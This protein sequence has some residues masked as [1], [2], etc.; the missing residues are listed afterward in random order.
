M[1]NQTPKPADPIIAMAREMTALVAKTNEY[2]RESRNTCCPIE[3]ERANNRHREAFSRLRAL[4]HLIS[5]TRA[6]SPEGAMAQCIIAASLVNFALGFSDSKE[7][8]SL[9]QHEMVSDLRRAGGIF[10]SVVAV[11][12]EI[13]G[14]DRDEL[15]AAYYMFREADPAIAWHG[16]AV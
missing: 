8:W 16:E 3:Q 9:N 1:R 14:T 12:E 11:L 15:C 2:D 13:S 7:Q 6:Q 10:Y 4:E 5:K